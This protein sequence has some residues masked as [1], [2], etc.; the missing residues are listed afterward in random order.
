MRGSN[1]KV[2]AG[3]RG[4]IG[5]DGHAVAARVDALYHDL[6][7]V[8]SVCKNFPHRPHRPFVVRVTVVVHVYN[9]GQPVES[10]GVDFMD[11]HRFVRDFVVIAG[12]QAGFDGVEVGR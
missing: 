8:L 3:K 6:E 12:K 10:G 1:Q 7:V 11:D 4:R 5:V 9:L 2:D